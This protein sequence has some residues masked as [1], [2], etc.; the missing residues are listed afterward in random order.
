[1]AAGLRGGKLAEVA[2]DFA[3][4]LGLRRLL[5]SL[6]RQP[7]GDAQAGFALSSRSRRADAK[8]L[9]AINAICRQTGRTAKD[10]QNLPLAVISSSERDPRYP[11]GSRAQRARSRFYQG[12]MQLQRELAALSAD[13][14]HVVAANAGHH[15]QRDDPELVINALTELVRGCVNPVNTGLTRRRRAT[16]GKARRNNTWPPKR[17]GKEAMRWCEVPT[18][19][20]FP[21]RACG[22]ATGPG[23]K[24]IPGEPASAAARAWRSPGTL[25][26]GVGI[27][28]LADPLPINTADDGMGRIAFLLLALFAEMERTFTAER[29]AHAR[30]VAKANGRQAGRPIA[31]RPDKIEYARL[32]HGQGK[33]YGEISVKKRGHG[34]RNE[35]TISILNSSLTA[36]NRLRRALRE[37]AYRPAQ[38]LRSLSGEL[39]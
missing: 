16:R 25:L 29:P 38:N 23:F 15:V 24:S 39:P 21:Q 27:R 17:L 3:K 26:G 10:L 1:V 37:H 8:E 18:E 6:R 11:E 31:H 12:W 35:L 7:A 14:V 22:R 33:R 4:P 20:L 34:G 36:H 30:R 32:L 5:R 9:L 19:D 2:L 28:S 13:S